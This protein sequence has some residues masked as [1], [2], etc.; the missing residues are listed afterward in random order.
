MSLDFGHQ[1]SR[2]TVCS[3]VAAK[4]EAE[5]ILWLVCCGE[6]TLH[7]GALPIRAGLSPPFLGFAFL[8]LGRCSKTFLK[9]HI[10]CEALPLQ[11]RT[12]PGTNCSHPPDTPSQLLR[13][14]TQ[15]IL[16]HLP[17]S[18]HGLSTQPALGSSLRKLSP[19][20]R[21][22]STN[23]EDPHSVQDGSSSSPHC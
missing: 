3:D 13:L 4:L 5:N 14:R 1:G 16:N 9:K 11:C 22:T 15:N 7:R 17:K 21:H 6:N 2:T 18:S 8:N 20:E 19:F 10:R 12:S 23:D